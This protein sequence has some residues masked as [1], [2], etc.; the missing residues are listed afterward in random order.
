M[1]EWHKPT[2]PSRPE[3]PAETV[4]ALARRYRLEVDMAPTGSATTPEW[5]LVPGIT[6]FT[7]TAEPTIQDVSTYDTDGWAE[8][9][10]TMLTWQIELTIAHR[11]HPVTGQFNAAQE[12]LRRSALA[13]GAAA[14]VHLRFYDRF[15]A[16]DAHEGSALVTWEP[17]GGGPDEV[18]TI[19]VTL[20]G[21]G[22]LVP[23]PNPAGVVT[24]H[25]SREPTFAGD[26]DG[27]EVPG[28]A[29]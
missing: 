17:E 23:I 8:Q 10:K 19:S 1:H 2:P 7:P 9:A 16:Q 29:G 11:A 21:N 18:D 28:V 12:W 4:T 25:P 24:L 15:G 3:Q 5:A 27:P 26:D 22:P 14:Y 20:S 6:E 13:F